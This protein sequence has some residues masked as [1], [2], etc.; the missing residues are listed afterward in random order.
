LTGPPALRRRKPLAKAEAT[1]SGDR[2]MNP[3]FIIIP[4]ILV[5]AVLNRVEFGRFD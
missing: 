5:M 1:C 4:F 2:P 3:L